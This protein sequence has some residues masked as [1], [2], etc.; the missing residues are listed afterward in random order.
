[1][2]ASP[3]FDAT[4]PLGLIAGN[5]SFPL[6]FVAEAKRQ[7]FR[8]VVAAHSGETDPSVV[9]ACE[10]GTWVRLGEINKIIKFFRRHGVTKATFLGGI[11]RVRLFEALPFWGR[12]AGRSGRPLALDW[13]GVK[14]LRRARSA[15]DDRLLREV[16][17]EFQS[18]GIEIFSSTAVLGN[19][20]APAGVIVQGGDLSEEQR[21]DMLLGWD[22]ATSLGALDIGQTVVVSRG[23]VVALEGIDGTDA[24]I[25]RGG[26]LTR[27]SGGVVVKLVKPQQDSR[28]DLPAIGA[29]TIESMAAAGLSVLLIRAEFTLLFEPEAVIAAARAANVTIV[30]VSSR[31][32]VGVVG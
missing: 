4:K 11:R 18:C 30:A 9:S 13:R 22:A 23:M 24:T 28:L 7:G 12:F 14:V 25:L 8:C 32:E 6:A 26:T 31:D 27:G 5:G 19:W 1:M 15:L 16:V 20:V 21:K 3:D 2:S 29:K 17:A 10:V